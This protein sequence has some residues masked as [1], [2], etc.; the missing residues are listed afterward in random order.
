[1]T[2]ENGNVAELA[3]Q[4]KKLLNDPDTRTMLQ[5]NREEHLMKF[6]S[7]KVAAAYLDLMS[8]MIA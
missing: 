7:A 1:M 2:F 8:K 3:A 5:R 6:E 4:I